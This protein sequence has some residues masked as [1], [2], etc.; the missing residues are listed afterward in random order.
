MSAP[1]RVRPTTRLKGS[2]LPHE[3]SY[4]TKRTLQYAVTPAQESAA[5]FHMFR[6]AR[7]VQKPLCHA[8]FLLCPTGIVRVGFGLLSALPGMLTGLAVRLKCASTCRPEKAARLFSGSV[9]DATI[10]QARIAAG[11]N[12]SNQ[13]NARRTLAQS[14][15]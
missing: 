10:V 8:G 3:M 15:E 9:V 7:D 12:T 14:S 11:P 13:A 4:P 2:K 5:A 6:T 1:G